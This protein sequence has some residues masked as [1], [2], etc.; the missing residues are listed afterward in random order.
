MKM[1]TINK[2]ILF[3]LLTFGI[4]FSMAGIFWFNNGDLKSIP[5]LILSVCYM[6]IPMLSVLIIEKLIYHNELVKSL[7]IS[8]KLNKWFLIGWLIM[9][10]AAFLTLGISLLYIQVSFTP[11]MAGM[12]E[13]FSNMMTPEQLSQM[14][15]SISKL[16]GS[17]IFL[18]LGQGMIAGISINAIAGF[19]EELGWRGFL[20]K[21][22]SNMSFLKASLV[23]GF[24]WGIWHAPL[25]LMGHNYPQHPQI[26]VLMMVVWCILLTPIFIYI[27]LKAKSVIAAAI[28]HGTLNGVAGI[29][30]MFIKGGNDITV[31]LTGLS[32][33]IALAII[34]LCL[35]VYDFLISKQKIMLHSIEHSIL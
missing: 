27:T 4:C 24:I 25:I 15:D 3:L 7:N 9:P 18:I 34:I 31:G 6:F 10:F 21:Q 5:G 20:L 13:R 17:V 16:S 2:T 30:I 11:N 8:F 22:F 29:S 23:I 35:F 1:K 32:G 26:G 33:F 19:G 12:V 14:K 28:L